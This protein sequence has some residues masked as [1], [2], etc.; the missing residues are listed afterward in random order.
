MYAISSYQK[1]LIIQILVQSHTNEVGKGA[2]KQMILYNYVL[3]L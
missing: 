1:A 3:I 2:S